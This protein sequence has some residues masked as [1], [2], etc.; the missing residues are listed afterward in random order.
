M[1]KDVTKPTDEVT[2]RGRRIYNNVIPVWWFEFIWKDSLIALVRDTVND[3]S[4]AFFPRRIV[5]SLL[6]FLF[7]RSHTPAALG[8]FAASVNSL[9]LLS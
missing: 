9:Q 3:A 8:V 6:H 4:F 2:K 7:S 5:S 1:C